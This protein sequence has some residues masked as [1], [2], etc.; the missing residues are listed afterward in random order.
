MSKQLEKSLVRLTHEL[1]K[2]APVI[3]RKLRSAGVKP[4]PAVVDAAAMYYELLNRL[5]EE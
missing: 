3:R 2:N 4:N 1:E 5:A